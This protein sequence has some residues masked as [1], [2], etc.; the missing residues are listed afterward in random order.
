MAKGQPM[1]GLDR[2]FEVQ[3]NRVTLG[4]GVVTWT[5]AIISIALRRHGLDNDLTLSLTR[6]WM[7]VGSLMFLSGARV[8]QLTGSIGDSVGRVCREDDPSIFSFFIGVL[9][10]ASLGTLDLAIFL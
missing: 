6:T 10:S 5:L 8:G 1:D 4:L 2:L 3:G 9:Y 7:L